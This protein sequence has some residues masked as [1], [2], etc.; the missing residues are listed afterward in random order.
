[1]TSVTL[2]ACT[3]TCRCEDISPVLCRT[4][5]QAILP[6]SHR[7][8]CYVNVFQNYSG[9]KHFSTRHCWH[10]PAANRTHWS[11][12]PALAD[13]IFQ[14][15]LASKRGASLGHR[16]HSQPKLLFLYFPLYSVGKNTKKK[17]KKEK[18]VA[19]QQSGSFS[20]EQL[21]TICLFAQMHYILGKLS[22]DS[23]WLV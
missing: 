19:V 12:F 8:L 23:A 9:G 18:I 10:L 16:D 4:L 20:L 6:K 7:L 22:R 2:L 21:Q 11:F 5:C 1:M 14:I 13:S 17:K 15:S 3:H